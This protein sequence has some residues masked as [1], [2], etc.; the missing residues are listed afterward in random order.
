MSH[1]RLFYLLVMI[2]F[3]IGCGGGGSTIV[4]DIVLGIS[5][6]VPASAPPGSL[7][8]ANCSA[9]SAGDS[10]YEIEIENIMMPI[11]RFGDGFV[12][13]Y[14]PYF[15]VGAHPVRL[16][17]NGQTGDQTEYYIEDFGPL[18]YTQA[19]FTEVVR[20]GMTEIYDFDRWLFTAM[21]SAFE[22]Y[23]VNVLQ[24]IYTSLDDMGRLIDIVADVIAE[25]SPDDARV[26]QGL[27]R[28]S[29]VLVFFETSRTGTCAR[30][31]TRELNGFAPTHLGH[32]LIYKADQMSMI[33]TN[34]ESVLDVTTLI[35]AA[36][37]AVTGGTSAIPAGVA[38]TLKQILVWSDFFIDTFAITDFHKEE[39]LGRS[40]L[41]LTV[42]SHYI[43]PG[44]TSTMQF[45]GTFR[46]QDKPL[47]SLINTVINSITGLCLHEWVQTYGAPFFQQ[48][49]A[50]LGLK[51]TTNLV[52]WLETKIE[53][54]EWCA[55]EY[56]VEM[57]MSL[58]NVAYTDFLVLLFPNASVLQLVDILRAFDLV[59]VLDYSVKIDDESVLFYN[60]TTDEIAGLADGSTTISAKAYSMRPGSF[61]GL[62]NYEWQDQVMSNICNITVGS[63]FPPKQPP[64]ALATASN[65]YP[66]PGEIVYFAD[67]GSYDPDG[68]DIVEY[69]WD[70]NNDGL[71]DSSGSTQSHSWPTEGTYYVNFIVTDDEQYTDELDTPFTIVVSEDPPPNQVAN[72]SFDEGSST[73]VHDS[74][75][76]AYDGTQSNPDNWG[77]TAEAYLGN[78]CFEQVSG[79]NCVTFPG[80]PLDNRNS[81]AIDLYAMFYQYGSEGYENSILTHASGI[82]LDDLSIF[83]YNGEIDVVIRDFASLSSGPSSVNLNHWHHI[84]L[85]L[86][87]SQYILYLDG[88]PVDSEPQTGPLGVRSFIRVGNGNYGN[89]CYNQRPL[90]G[91]LDKVIIEGL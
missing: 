65:C 68:G 70:W 71:L 23:P 46:T 89:S 8:K 76:N 69:A 58:Y 83:E 55:K 74:S 88:E 47:A 3:L 78:S 26:L 85:E 32:F 45:T 4:P 31:A 13:F 44:E 14:I 1:S 37:A 67:N 5:G 57:D 73:I 84:R 75:G 81:V 39:E 43:D 18:T 16:V 40:P 17:G 80:D 60:Y 10:G 56:E 41:E 38:L 21:Y 72:W 79:K 11:T 20:E 9:I 53:N 86:T 25:M 64:V 59:P 49:L 52:S 27:F 51:A 15:P 2:P 6:F 19:E 61:F 91:R 34:L 12:E 62:L 33:C 50:K 42:G 77:T 22:P 29:G 66:E 28:E 87:G 35:C 36:A 7:V 48:Q 82:G 30:E 90:I 63:G 24:D 54:Q